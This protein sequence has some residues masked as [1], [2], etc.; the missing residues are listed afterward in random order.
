[1]N[2]YVCRNTDG[3]IRAIPEVFGVI[4]V[5]GCVE[6]VT[7]TKY[8]DRLYP[9]LILTVA[10]CKQLFGDVPE[11]ERAYLVTKVDSDNPVWERIDDELYLMDEFG[12]QIVEEVED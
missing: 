7:D 11:K 12:K 10:Q 5:E 4:K 8:Y 3:Q 2:F 1:M 6:F 9:L